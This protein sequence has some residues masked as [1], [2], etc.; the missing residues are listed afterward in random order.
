[1]VP[2]TLWDL[3][4][5]LTAPARSS[6][7]FTSKLKA[8]RLFRE[9][10]VLKRRQKSED[11]ICEEKA[12]SVAVPENWPDTRTDWPTDRRLQDNLNLSSDCPVIEVSSF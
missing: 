6:S 2:Q 1:M 8:S 5:R 3:D 7:T 12:K 11:N 9:S 4:P 10:S